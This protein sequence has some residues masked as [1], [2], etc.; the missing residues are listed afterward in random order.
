MIHGRL[1]NEAETDPT[2]TAPENESTLLSR[3]QLAQSQRSE[4][5]VFLLWILAIS[6]L[7]AF[8]FFAS[9]LC[10]T[11]LL[12]GFLA[13]LVD[14]V[15]TYFERLRVPRMLSSALMIIAGTALI[16]TLTYHSYQP[17][18]D[19]VDHMPTYARR[20]AEAVRPLVRKIEKVGGASGGS[21]AVVTRE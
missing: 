3:A 11:V 15:I 18:A 4:Q 1:T 5:I 19:V 13:I 8:C 12:A 2:K 7:L 21:A 6:A 20:I 9:W 17:I 16:G 10:I 14:P